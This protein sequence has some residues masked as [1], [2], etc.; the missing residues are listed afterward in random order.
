VSLTSAETFGKLRLRQGAARDALLPRLL[1]QLAWSPDQLRA[2]RE[3]RMRLLLATAKMRSPWHRERLRHV[4]ADAFTEADLTALPTMTKD[5]LMD[6]FDGVVTDPRLTRST[7]DAYVECPPE[8]LYLLG[9]Y[10]VCASG[11][12]SGR[13]GVFVMD[14][15]AFSTMH[16]EILRWGVQNQIPMH[17]SWANLSAPRGAHISWTM[18]AVFPPPI[19]ITSIPPTLPLAEIVQ[20]LNALQPSRISGYASTF[21]LLAGETWAGRLHIAPTFISTC[22]EPL[23]PEAREAIER[24]WPL[25]VYNFYGATEGPYAMPC[26]AGDAMHLPDDLCYV[27]PVDEAG[28]PV[29]PG[30]PSAKLLLTNLFNLTQPLIRYEVTDQ[31]V[32]VPE[33]CP[34]GVAARRIDQVLGR[35]DDTFTYPGGV[36]VHPLTIRAPLGRHRHVAEYQVV[37]TPR[38]VCVR[39]CAIGEVDAGALATTIVTGLRG[40]GLADPDV[41]LEQV[42][43]LPRQ[44]SGKMKRFIPLA[45]R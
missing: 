13:R 31:V 26:R 7:V 41:S 40:C 11:G 12:S 19:P 37:Q 29:P 38:G 30:M 5:D 35:M 27:E 34:C 44:I 42:S 45:A 8:N 18:L 32:V 17:G 15:D 9:E 33:A 16:C 28:N 10:L 25:H 1:A 3:R 23:L 39:F 20:R 2:E 22:G 24:A 43:E 36:C 21:A 6:N 4:D 14:R